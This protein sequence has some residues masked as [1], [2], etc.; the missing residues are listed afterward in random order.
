VPLPEFQQYQYAFTGHIRDPKKRA[1]PAGVQA[2]RM[3]VY[4]ELLFNNLRGFLDA[5]FPVSRDTL[6]ARRWPSLVRTFL[7]D[8]RCLTPHYREIPRE[9]V[10]YLMEAA[11]DQPP[12]LMELAHYEWAELA[13]DIMDAPTAPAFDPEGDLLDGRPVLAT[14]R[15]GLANVKIIHAIMDSAARRMPVEIKL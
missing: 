1:R 8:W 6:G 2:R 9:F 13:V 7:R 15:E 3:D 14:G 5:C 12:W 10:R 4:N 11:A